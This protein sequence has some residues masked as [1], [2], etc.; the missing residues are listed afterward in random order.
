TTLIGYRPLVISA[1]MVI[2]ML[3]VVGLGFIML[4]KHEVVF[5]RSA[6]TSGEHW[7][8]LPIVS[9]PHP[10]DE[11]PT[12]AANP[13]RTSWTSEE[14][15]GNLQVEWYRPIEA[16][17]SQNV[18]VIASQGLLYISTARGLY[19]LS[20]ENG[21]EVW[22]FNTDMPIGNSPTVYNGVVYLGGYDRNLHALDATSGTL[23][24]SFDQASAGYST[25]PLAV[26]G[27]IFAGN[28]DGYMYAIGAQGTPQQGQLLWRY[29][30]D[31]PI[32]LSAAYQDGVVYFASNDNH[33]YALRAEDGHLM[34]KSE[35]LPGDGYQS[36]WPVIYKDQVIFSAAVS[37]RPDV[38]PGTRSVSDGLQYYFL[39]GIWPDLVEG[40]LIGP[41]GPPQDWANGFPTVDAHL[42]T[43]YYENNPT[44]DENPHAHKPWRRPYIVLNLDT[45]EEFTFDSDGDGYPEYMPGF[46][47]HT[48]SGNIYPGIVGEDDILYHNNAFRCCGDAKGKVYGWNIDTPELLSMVGV[49][50]FGDPGGGFAAMAEPQAI[51][52]GGKIIYRN[53]CCDRVGD[54]F[55][56]VAPARS[57]SF[58]SY[59]L[60][61]QATEYDEMWFFYPESISRLWAWYQGDEPFYENKEIDPH[62]Y[63][64]VNGI[65]ASHGT[66]NPLIPYR[67]RIYIHRSN[68]IIAYGSGN[69]PGQLPLLEIQTPQQHSSP[70]SQSAMTNWLEAEI[71]KVV[72]AGDLRPGYY[73]IGQHAEY[74]QLWDYFNNPG[75]TLYTLSSAY[76]YLSP[77]LQSQVR[78]YLSNYYQKYF[79]ENMYATTGWLDGAPR[80]AMPLPEDILAYIYDPARDPN[81]SQDRVLF[82]RTSVPGF[83]WSYPP[84]NMYALFTYALNVPGVDVLSAYNLAKSRLVVPVPPVATT[85]WFQERPYEHNAYLTGYI[86]FLKLQDLAGMTE[87]DSELRQQVTLELDRLLQL[88][89]EIFDK[90]TWWVEN[91]ELFP[92]D[93]EDPE[94]PKPTNIYQRKEMD[95]ARNFMWLVPELGDY[96]NQNIQPKVQ[97]AVD[98]YNYVA[99]Y[100]FVSRYESFPGEGVSSV[101]WNYPAVF[102]AKAYALQQ[103]YEELAKYIDAPAFQRGDLFH[104]Q[105]MV[106]ALQATTLG[107]THQPR[108]DSEYWSD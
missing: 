69:G 26:D 96:L 34:W 101:L 20:A 107:P 80:E 27:R 31:G 15:S 76:P 74:K 11:W 83:S 30:T 39:R 44:G 53:L 72:D 9:K 73:V 62:T 45:G 33:A 91:P 81:N 92:E 28:R 32:N 25:N 49:R 63:N 82:P 79:V 105:N 59:N 100:W 36:Y 64:S 51:S 55:S 87:Q 8:Y 90:D 37:Y 97:E 104:I 38:N 95:I 102:Q 2:T 19:A 50:N 66:Q 24:W 12:A 71:Q 22:R 17:I 47:W 85:R 4:Y 86:G 60:S 88:K 103:P 10:G 35:K 70:P 93:P 106:A 46:W 42:L 14:I 40:E 18:Q 68:A 6:H 84:H 94:D 108:L 78:S 77:S 65:Y 41:E 21:A 57:G 58:W 61:N 99:P 43:Q 16:Y 56:T 98:E 48:S 3:A 54:W 89:Y 7:A 1:V 75:D 52:G 13:Q 29:K 67:G 5:A 23:L